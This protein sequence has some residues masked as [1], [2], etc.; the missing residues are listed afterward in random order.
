MD[1]FR[2]SFLLFCVVCVVVI[3]S[4]GIY[5]FAPIVQTAVFEEVEAGTVTPKFEVKDLGWL[6]VIEDLGPVEEN[7]SLHGYRFSLTGDKD[8]KELSPIRNVVVD[9]SRGPGSFGPYLQ[10]SRG[11]GEATMLHIYA[12]DIQGTTACDTVY[13]VGTGFQSGNLAYEIYLSHEQETKK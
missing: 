2:F 11:I 1:S 10:I 3:V 8:E 9:V 6:P 7:G 13:F 5:K 12:L 4:G